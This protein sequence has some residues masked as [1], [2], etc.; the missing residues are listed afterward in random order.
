[1]SKILLTRCW[2]AHYL[3]PCLASDV[4][5]VNASMS[6]ALILSFGSEKSV[7]DTQFKGTALTHVKDTYLRGV[8]LLNLYNRNKSLLTTGD[9]TLTR[10]SCV[11]SWLRQYYD[12]SFKFILP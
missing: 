7:I 4:S 9:F 5:L 11:W 10:G 3:F 1:M 12:V 2:I 8:I 6:T